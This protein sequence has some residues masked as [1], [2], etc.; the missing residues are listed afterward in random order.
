MLGLVCKGSAGCGMARCNLR[1]ARGSQSHTLKV[2][3]FEALSIRKAA[4][5]KEKHILVIK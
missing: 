2:G 1:L 5:Q 4:L 3:R